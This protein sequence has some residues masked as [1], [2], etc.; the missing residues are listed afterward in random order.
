MNGQAA[1][2][3]AVLVFQA[4]PGLAE[5]ITPEMRREDSRLEKPVTVALER[6][7]VGELLKALSEQTKV[8][9]SASDK[10]GAADPVLRVDLRAVPL[11]E[12]LD[13]LWSLLS[14][15]GARWHWVRE[16]VDGQFR[17]SLTRPLAARNLPA[18]LRDG[19]QTLFEQE[20]EK[21]R[22]YLRMGPAEL[23][24]HAE[25][26]RQSKAILTSPTHRTGLQIFF[27]CIPPAV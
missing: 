22:A 15:K 20:A 13:A 27:D 23:E 26:D 19:I 11:F 14:Y 18:Q 25:S 10:D 8:P 2:V 9:L 4:M 5:T 1:S 24:R 12:A 21:T 16:D 17:Y 6:A 7:R 3:L